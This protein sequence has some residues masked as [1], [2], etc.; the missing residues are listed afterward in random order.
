M[1]GA[2]AM[3]LAARR[4]GVS[5][6]A[7]SQS[8]PEQY[9]FAKKV[10]LEVVCLCGTCPKRTIT[11]CD[12]GWAVRNQYAILHAVINGKTSEQI[13]GAYREVY[14]QEVLAMLPHE[15]L[16]DI[17]WALPYGGAIVGLGFALWVGVKLMRR[18]KEQ[19]EP[20]LPPEPTDTNDASDRAKLNRELEDLD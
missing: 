13:I 6:N 8:T 18:S 17:A 9:E 11:E 14:G 12:C 3:D 15:G 20:E 7:P 5:M 2:P 10:G 1:Q 16:N 19:P 4:M